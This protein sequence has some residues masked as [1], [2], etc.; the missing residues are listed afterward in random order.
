VRYCGTLGIDGVDFSVLLLQEKHAGDL[1]GLRRE[2]ERAHLQVAMLVCYSDFTTP[3]QHQRRSQV[4][5]T[6]ANIRLARTLG[7][8]LLRVTAGQRYPGVTRRQGVAWVQE[9]LRLLLPE[10]DRLGITLAYE[11]HSKGAPW[12]YW[13]FSQSTEIFL[14]I[15]DG[16]RDTSLRVN[17]DTANALVVN[18]D[19]L[20]LLAA[21]KDRVVSLHAADVRAPGALEPVI[22]GTGVAPLRQCF[23]VVK[24]SGFD[25]WISIEEASRT[26]PAGFE[27]AVAFVRKTWAQA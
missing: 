5:D 16:L 1:V 9:S 15:L 22:V 19:P 24:D 6:R 8:T 21:V 7:A 4:D 26:G 14:E 3:D 20:N 17:F 10:A 12:R 18:E 2:I 13:D 11:N 27:Q 23:S 25:G